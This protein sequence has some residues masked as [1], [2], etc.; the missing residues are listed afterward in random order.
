MK[1]ILDQTFKY[2]S[3]ADT[4]VRR[5]FRRVRRQL[6]A[7]VG[8]RSIPLRTPEPKGTVLPMLERRRLAK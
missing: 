6:H 8:Q 3:A 4:D 2:Y 1:S 7:D 5:T